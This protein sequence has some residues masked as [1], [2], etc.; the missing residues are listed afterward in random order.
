MRRPPPFVAVPVLALAFLVGSPPL[1]AADPSSAILG[2][3]RGTSTCTDLER[4]PACKNEVVVYRFTPAKGKVP[5]RTT[6]AA[7]KIVDGQEVPMGEMDFSW[8]GAKGWTSEF[9]TPR[10]HALW[11][12]AVDGPELTGTLVDLPT[13][14]TLRRVKATRE[15]R[16]GK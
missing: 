8:D 2:T 1:A 4:A 11:A 5:G 12:Y 13:K 7:A 16:P 9:T 3:W 15:A 14:S 10:F 6:L